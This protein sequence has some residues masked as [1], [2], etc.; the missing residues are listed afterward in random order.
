M[1]QIRASADCSLKLSPAQFG[2]AEMLERIR[3]LRRR[4]RET[5]A[6]GGHA[7]AAACSSGRR[8]RRPRG[9]PGW[10]ADTSLHN[11]PLDDGSQWGVYQADGDNWTLAPVPAPVDG[12]DETF[13]PSITHHPAW[14]RGPARGSVLRQAPRA[15]AGPCR[16]VPCGPAT[17]ARSRPS[18][19][20]SPH[21]TL[22]PP[23]RLILRQASLCAPGR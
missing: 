1:N 4:V 6:R 9:C 10:K 20:A 18:S 21:P 7:C 2:D 14:G 11:R 13:A 15:A 12:S 5:P 17:H 8:G 23:G 16:G 19:T 3:L 22:T